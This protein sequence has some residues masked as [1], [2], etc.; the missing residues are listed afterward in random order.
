MARGLEGR[1][2]RLPQRRLVRWKSDG[3]G[4]NG[5][6]WCT[7]RRRAAAETAM[8]GALEGGR[9][10]GHGDGWCAGMPTAQ[11]ETAMAGGLEGGRL[12]LRRRWLVG[13]KADGCG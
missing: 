5:A 8:A 13:W 4:C 6:G 11:A 9:Q 2:Q 12:R 1:R 7:G 3:S 10:R